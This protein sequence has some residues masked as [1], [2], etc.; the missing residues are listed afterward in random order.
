MTADSMDSLCEEFAAACMTKP[1]R[2]QGKR[3][4]PFVNILRSAKTLA[5]FPFIVYP[6]LV[7][8]DILTVP[9]VPVEVCDKRSGIVDTAPESDGKIFSSVVASRLSCWS[10]I[11][12]RI[13]WHKKGFK[14]NEGC[15]ELNFVL[16]PAIVQA[17]RSEKDSSLAWLDLE[18]AF[19]ALP[20]E[21]IF[22]SLI[23]AGVPDLIC[24]IISMCSDACS[25]IRC[26]DYRTT[27]IPMSAGVR[28]V[29]QVLFYSICRLSKF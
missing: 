25:S 22:R 8:S 10:F 2:S 5:E 3:C 11:N 14:E 26:E 7:A 29:F 21:F 4:C 27:S 18:N 17:K 19:G 12:D 16:D 15:V 9:F 23:S 24:S 20:H 6:D 13:D 28:S 1:N